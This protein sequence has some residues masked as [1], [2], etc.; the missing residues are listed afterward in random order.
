MKN[1]IPNCM[2]KLIV[3]FVYFTVFT[4]DIYHYTELYNILKVNTILLVQ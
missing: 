4:Y 2:K 3:Y 1:K